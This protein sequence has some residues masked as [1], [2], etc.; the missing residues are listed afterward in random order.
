MV[1]HAD[2]G[3]TDGDVETNAVVTHADLTYAERDAGEI[4]L[5]LYRPDTERAVPL[6]V[7]VHGGGWVAETRKN[8]PDFER[9]AVEW[10][11]AIASVS[12]RLAEVP[13]HVEPPLSVD[14]A[15]ETPRGVFP[16]QIIDVKA[17]IRWL[18]AHAD[19]FGYDASAVA[20]WGA[21]A[22]GHLAALAGV[23]D[24]IE[25]LAGD[26]Y[27]KQTLDPV[28]APEASGRVQAVITWYPITD[29]RSLP[30]AE[31]GVTS[32]LL[33]GSVAEYPDCARLASPVTHVTADSPPVLLLHGQADDVVPIEQ[34]Q[35]LFDELAAHNAEAACYEVLDLGH[36]W[37]ADSE[38]TA[39]DV[40]ESEPR[41]DY[42][43]T[44]TPQFGKTAATDQ[45]LDGQRPVGPGLINAF[46]DRN[47]QR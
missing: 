20:V 40:L 35:T 6:V 14:P 19:E 27:S 32:L 37:G 11:C 17:A 9:F 8:T 4:K 26:T 38:R 33:G 25:D 16:D 7:Y 39:M 22:G 13:E 21:S 44:A 5:D 12:Y 42:Q 2:S 23:V 34:S 36:C 41:P 15:N 18:R 31:D 1:D 43:F 3:E 46:L 24:D 10:D 28:V 30:D 47:T 45:P 29:L